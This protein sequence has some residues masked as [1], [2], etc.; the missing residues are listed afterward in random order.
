MR[1]RR[2][3]K[4]SDWSKLSVNEPFLSYELRKN[5]VF[6]QILILTLFGLLIHLV[7]D[8]IRGDFGVAAF[9]VLTTVITLISYLLNERKRHKASK[10]FFF[11]SINVVFFILASLVPRECAVG[12]LFLALIGVALVVHPKSELK[13]SILYASFSLAALIT[14]E[15]TDYHI[16]GSTRMLEKSSLFNSIINITSACL[17]LSVCILFAIQLNYRAEV[18]LLKRE[19]Q[20]AKTNGKLD[21]ILYSASHDLRAP[22][23]SIK[24]LVNLAAME[25]EKENMGQYFKLIDNRIA[26]LDRFI[27]D[28]LEFSRNTKNQ[29]IIE[30]VSVNELVNEI[31]DSLRYMD[32]ASRIRLIREFGTV[33]FV[34]TDRKSLSVILA[35]LV[36]NSV[37]YH[38][39]HQ[40]DLW[41]K[42]F[43]EQEAGGVRLTISDNG[44]GISP[45]QQP[46]VF[47]MFHRATEISTGSGLGLFIIK[48]V[49]DKLNGQISLQSVFGKGS[50]FSI[51]IPN[52]PNGV[53][54]N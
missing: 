24:G 26:K 30:A 41:I 6:S 35:N 4:P 17:I 38:N 10:F 16:F 9:V 40:E 28:I 53:E 39:Y 32:G 27:L 48:E 34:N 21:Q 11:I 29:L 14:L 42:I 3:L 12:T 37:K 46:K 45:E 54:S 51:S 1:L 52:A 25:P 22:L 20:L 33:D 49:V 50:T 44:I 7:A 5:I 23:N 43:M 47:D 13:M 18:L 8:S 31:A 15:L 2:L 36:S 19:N